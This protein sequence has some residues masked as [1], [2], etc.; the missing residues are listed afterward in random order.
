MY[1]FSGI[2]VEVLYFLKENEKIEE[3]R[4]KNEL[5]KQSSLKNSKNEKRTSHALN[6]FR[7]YAKHVM[8]AGDFCLNFP[9]DV[10]S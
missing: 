6:A 10:V 8:T 2:Y 9:A 4:S 7:K 3:Q 5:Q 1:I